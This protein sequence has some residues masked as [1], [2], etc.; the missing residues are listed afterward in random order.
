MM[1][2]EDRRGLLRA[3][4]AVG[5]GTRCARDEV[6]AR[7][8]GAPRLRDWTAGMSGAEANRVGRG[9]WQ[10]R[11]S[12][13][14][15]GRVA[16]AS[17]S[18]PSK[19]PRSTPALPPGLYTSPPRYAAPVPLFFPSLPPLF[20][21]RAFSCAFLSTAVLSFPVLSVP[22][23]PQFILL[24]Q[25]QSCSSPFL[26]PSFW[27]LSSSRSLCSVMQPPLLPQSAMRR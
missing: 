20:Q 9:A 19:L 6:W 25:A 14:A 17:L 5:S 13:V 11:W 21:G 26:S 7:T 12:R 1:A 24:R 22:V 15:T 8:S 27:P 18:T 23:R 3:C 4:E 10:P 16:T 2:T